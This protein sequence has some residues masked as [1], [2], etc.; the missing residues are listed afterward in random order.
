MEAWTD[1]ALL[2]DSAYLRSVTLGVYVMHST[3]MRRF[4]RA[5]AVG[6]RE[7]GNNA[8][9]RLVQCSNRL[10]TPW[11]AKH[12]PWEYLVLVPLPDTDA[13]TL[14][15]AEKVVF[16]RLCEV[17]QHVHESGFESGEPELLRVATVWGMLS[18]LQRRSFL[19]L[20]PTT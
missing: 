5:G 9:N 17:A 13:P 7:K 8:L 19:L 12:A 6:I 15:A 18:F 10:G 3:T 16:G 20:P 14:R 11:T 2:K 1:P 4:F